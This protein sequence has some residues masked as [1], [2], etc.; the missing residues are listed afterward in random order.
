MIGLELYFL[1]LM[2]PPQNVPVVA[3]SIGL[4]TVVK[5]PEPREDLE[6]RFPN[7]GPH[8]TKGTL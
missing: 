6:S 3:G 7:L 8:T 1:A 4:S 5:Y 2:H